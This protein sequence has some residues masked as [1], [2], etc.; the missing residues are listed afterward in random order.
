MKPF[1]FITDFDGTMTKRDFYGIIIDEY[2]GEEG[3]K[4][5]LDWKKENKIG[6]EFLNKIFSWHEFNQDELMELLS[7]IELEPYAKSLYQFVKEKGGDFLIL[8]AGFNYYIEH[9]LKREGLTELEY[10]TN[11][12][13]FENN[14]FEMRPDSSKYYFSELYGVDKELVVKKHKELYEKVIYAGD[15]EPDLKAALASDIV[16]AKGE[17]KELLSKMDKAFYSIDNFNEAIQI[18]KEVL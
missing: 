7:K 16:F 12:G 13:V 11:P 10:I 1:I 3:K 4:Y 17:L 9:T 8:S 2:I 5:Y 18:L 14:I 6:V 15:S